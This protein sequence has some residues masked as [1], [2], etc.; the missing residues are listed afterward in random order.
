MKLYYYKAPGGN[1]GDDLNPWL[2][3]RLIPE[4]LDEDD[5]TLFVGIGT[6]LN[7]RVP[8]A[9]RKLVFGSGAGYG[10]TLKP[11]SRWKFYCVRGPLTAEVLGL[12]RKLAITDAAALIAQEVHAPESRSIV[13]FMPHHDSMSRADWR[14]ISEAA[15]LH[16]IDPT[17]PVEETL[18]AINRSKF[19]VAEAMHGAIVADALRVPWIPI[20]CYSHVLDFKWQDWCS[21]L[22]MTYKPFV[23]PEIWDA[24]R[25][26]GAKAKLINQIKRGGMKL[27]IGA[28]WTPPP[29]P[30]SSA[31]QFDS[32]IHQ[33]KKIA[34]VANTEL[35]EDQIFN[36][37]LERL[38][39]QL[40]QLRNSHLR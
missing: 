14:A 29:P 36:G 25:G 20:K 16:Y 11:D 30:K 1:F 22:G 39:E 10:E 40:W 27:R 3:N 37:A 17:S 5:S 21:S 7:H 32:A 23:L 15:G 6:L 19:V 33:L 35:S 28:E 9:P 12:D 13:S 18:Q 31:A 26:L 34:D 4:L 2:W 38:Q 8:V 24:E